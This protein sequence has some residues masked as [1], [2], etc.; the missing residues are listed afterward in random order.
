M[1]YICNSIRLT[2][3]LLQEYRLCKI[4]T[5]YRANEEGR[6]ILLS[7]KKK[8]KKIFYE[9]NISVIYIRECKYVK[10]SLAHC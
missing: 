10:M 5:I 7:L 8:K 1:E 6:S 9:C 2:C 4:F 3:S